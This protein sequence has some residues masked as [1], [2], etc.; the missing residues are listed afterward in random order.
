G[1]GRGARP[2]APRRARPLRRASGRRG[3]SPCRGPCSP[4]PWPR[5][6]AR[7]RARA[8]GCHWAG[9]PPPP[10]PSACPR[11]DRPSAR[12][13][14]R[15]GR[16]PRGPRRGR[17][18][19]S[20][21]PQ[22][23]AAPEGAARPDDNTAAPSGRG[24]TDRRQ[25][26]RSARN[27]P[28]RPGER[29][30]KIKAGT[31]GATASVDRIG[32]YHL[33]KGLGRGGT[34]VVY[35]ATEPDLGLTVALKLVGP[36]AKD[37]AALRTRFL[38]DARAVAALGHVN[39]AQIYDAQEHESQAFVAMELVPGV[40]LEQAARSTRPYPVVWVLDV[41]RQI[42]DGLAHAHQGGLV[43][44]DLKPTDVRVTPEGEVKLVDFGIANLKSF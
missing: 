34:G 4:P 20:R 12:G 22:D 5:P 36:L 37:A 29:R 27:V 2:G 14:G 28:G 8:P 7:P 13:R 18:P 35:E 19:G 15:P 40:D 38:R 6:R 26:R 25:T 24:G 31:P 11:S 33:L 44:R 1:G 16:S 30:T 17:R 43:H 10:D 39:L 3:S 41:L 23:A 21:L 32:K 9:G 42:C